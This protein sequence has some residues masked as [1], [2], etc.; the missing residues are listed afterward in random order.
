MYEI[1][2]LYILSDKIYWYVFHAFAIWSSKT[3]PLEIYY[4]L[5]ILPHWFHVY[6][7]QCWPQTLAA[8]SRHMGIWDVFCVRQGKYILGL[9]N[10]N[11][12]IHSLWA[13]SD[14]MWW[15][16]PGSTLAQVMTCCLTAPSHYLNQCWLIISEVQWH[17]VENNFTRK[18]WAINK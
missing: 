7:C 1:L 11:I 16:R 5:N 12:P 6:A 8:I 14:I 10:Y 13:S 9:G 17:S 3:F 15:H 2:S 18:T 4:G